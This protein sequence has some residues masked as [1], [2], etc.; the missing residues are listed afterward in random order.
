[1]LYKHVTDDLASKKL[2][3]PFLV[4]LGFLF[5]WFGYLG[6]NPKSKLY[7]EDVHALGHP[8]AQPILPLNK[9]TLVF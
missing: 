2:L 9:I 1:M 7:E 6:K 4:C 3:N 5:V 8:S